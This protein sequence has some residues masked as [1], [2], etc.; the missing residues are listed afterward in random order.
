MARTTPMVKS[1]LKGRTNIDGVN[2]R[3][4]WSA[5][6]LVLYPPAIVVVVNHDAHREK[7]HAR[8]HSDNSM[9]LSVL[10]DSDWRTIRTEPRPLLRCPEPGCGVELVS[11]Q[12]RNGTRFLRVKSRADSCSHHFARSGGGPESEM[13]IWMKRALHQVCMNLGLRARIEDWET[14]SDVLIVDPPISLEVQNRYDKTL[15]TRTTHR[16]AVG[17]DVIWFF[18]EQATGKRANAQLFGG[19]AVRLIVRDSDRRP[20]A[21]WVDG[22]DGQLYVQATVVG[23]THN[24]GFDTRSM[25]VDQFISEVAS[26][27]RAWYPYVAAV[28]D[29]WGRPRSGWVHQRDVLAAGATNKPRPPTSAPPQV[30][31]FAPKPS[32]SASADAPE[33]KRQASLAPAR[34]EESQNVPAP[35]AHPDPT[36][37]RVVPPT[38]VSRTSR[39][40]DPATSSAGVR[41]LTVLVIGG[42]AIGIAVAVF[43]LLLVLRLES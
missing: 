16:S 26:G 6:R 21:P 20:V 11:V 22:T 14:R 29:H 31:A 15:P 19:P 30:A 42:A 10:D 8:L 7:R 4:A 18:T 40:S 13:H 23:R 35:P 28:V 5:C 2:G 25:T 34:Q 24:G 36:A 1:C 41:R 17:S 39:C 12:K 3:D 38:Q 43:V 37:G 32:N 9:I 27:D 33:P